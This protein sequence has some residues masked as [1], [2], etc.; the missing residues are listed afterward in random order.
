MKGLFIKTLCFLTPKS[1]FPLFLILVN[2]N[3][4]LPI[5]QAKHLCVLLDSSVSFMPHIN[6]ISKS[7]ALCSTRTWMWPGHC[8]STVTALVKPSI[9]TLLDYSNRL[10][11]RLSTSSLLYA[12]TSCTHLLLNI[13]THFCQLKNLL[14]H[15]S[16]WCPKTTKAWV[17]TLQKCTLLLSPSASSLPKEREWEHSVPSSPSLGRR[18]CE[19]RDMV[20]SFSCGSQDPSS[21]EEKRFLKSLF[22]VVQRNRRKLEL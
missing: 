15:K 5:L 21:W 20:P 8:T 6:S 2:G 19:E 10:L 7:S 3:S 17:E 4:F 9:T 14:G 18:G 11:T 22:S 16:R 1:P 13:C 12:V